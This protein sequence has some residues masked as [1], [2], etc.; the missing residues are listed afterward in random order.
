MNDTTSLPPGGRSSFE[1]TPGKLNRIETNTPARFEIVTQA[2]TII[3]GTLVPNAPIEITP[4]DDIVSVHINLLPRP[5]LQ[6]FD[7]D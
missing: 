4:H 1:I 7:T 6:Q 5:D 3:A 2:G